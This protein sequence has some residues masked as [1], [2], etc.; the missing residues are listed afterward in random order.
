LSSLA[1]AAVKPT[2][3]ALL[4]LFSRTSD[5]MIAIDP[6]SRIVGWNQAAID[7]FGYTKEEVMGRCCAEVLQWRGRGLRLIC[8]P[9]CPISVR[10]AEGLVSDAQ[11]VMA[12]AK[13]GRSIWLSVSTVVL[14]REHHRVC[15]L[16]HFV[17]EIDPPNDEGAI[18]GGGRGTYSNRELELLGKLT[19]RE[20][21]VLDLLTR[22]MGTDE[23]ANRLGI[24]RTTIR[25]HVQ[26]IL[27][28]LEV[29]NRAEAIGTAM[30]WDR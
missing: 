12:T 10:A 14:P 28:K 18:L 16:V 26:R 5:G 15:R 23:M 8:G 7:L 29:H 27:A 25:N 11:S 19:R 30:R 17:R 20:K 6:V 22:A 2:S 21:K 4:D 3:K 1:S 9:E 24:S 13:S